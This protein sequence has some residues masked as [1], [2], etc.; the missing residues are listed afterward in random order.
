M[1]ETGTVVDI[2]GGQY[3]TGELL[4]YIVILVGGLG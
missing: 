1:S 4:K 2:V 3:C